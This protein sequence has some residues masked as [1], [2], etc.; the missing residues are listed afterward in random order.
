MDESAVFVL[1]FGQELCIFQVNV[2]NNDSLKKKKKKKSEIRSAK[3]VFE[4]C[5]LCV[6]YDVRVL[7]VWCCLSFFVFGIG[8]CKGLKNDFRVILWPLGPPLGRVWILQFTA[9]GGGE[10][11]AF[12]HFGM[13]RWFAWHLWWLLIF[14]LASEIA[15]IWELFQLLLGPV[16]YGGWFGLGRLA[17]CSGTKTKRKSKF[18]RTAVGKKSEFKAGFLRGGNC[19]AFFIQVS[20]WDFYWQKNWPKS[21]KNSDQILKIVQSPFWNSRLDLGW[22]L[23]NCPNLA[24][25]CQNFNLFIPKCPW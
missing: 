16:W 21:E 2:G 9:N 23:S 13:W 24:K 18:W 10:K 4:W 14:F 12:L 6:G 8:Y 3:V 17:C 19:T 5:V 15:G 22:K 7:W 1:G 20:S 25:S 11:C